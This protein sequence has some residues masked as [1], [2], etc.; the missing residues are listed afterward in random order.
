MENTRG[1]SLE[2]AVSEARRLRQDLSAKIILQEE[3]S[4][5][6]TIDMMTFWAYGN[7]SVP[8]D[9]TLRVVT[10]PEESI[11]DTEKREAAKRELTR[12]YKYSGWYSAR[13]A[14]GIALFDKEQIMGNVDLWMTGMKNRL[15]TMAGQ[16]GM[17]EGCGCNSPI[18]R[19]SPAEMGEPC[20][21]DGER[22]N[23]VKDL[24]KLY[25]LSG[26]SMLEKELDDV[27]A[28]N[29]SKAARIEAGRQIGYPDLRIWLHEMI[30]KTR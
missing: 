29:G 9:Q 16:E 24:A 12:I 28:N 26:L 3:E 22:V 25:Y 21:D 18:I 10:K 1:L 15:N 27:Y 23:A 2:E 7:W 14:A 19:G 17:G 8:C 5:S 30:R 4:Y 6:E 20:P 11:P 13:Y